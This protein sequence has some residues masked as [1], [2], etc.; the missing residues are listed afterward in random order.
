MKTENLKQ[1]AA[2]KLRGNFDQVQATFREFEQTKEKVRRK[3]VLPAGNQTDIPMGVLAF[4]A[5]VP[6]S[7]VYSASYARFTTNCII[8]IL[9][10]GSQRNVEGW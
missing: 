2:T 7:Y 5:A 3:A 10:D 9:T 4:R 1:F 8:L 6:E